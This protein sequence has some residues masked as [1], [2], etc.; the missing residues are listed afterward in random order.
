MES[1]V[2]SLSKAQPLFTIAGVILNTTNLVDNGI[3]P[4]I[5]SLLLPSLAT[6]YGVPLL[7]NS[8]NH[9]F[10]IT[11]ESLFVYLVGFAL[12]LVFF[13]NRLVLFFIGELP[14]ISKVISS[15][16][17]IHSPECSKEIITNQIISALLGIAIRRVVLRKS[18]RLKNSD[19]INILIYNSAIFTIRHFNLPAMSIVAVVYAAP[20]YGLISRYPAKKRAETPTV[21]HSRRQPSISQPSILHT[22]M[23]KMPRRRASVSSLLDIKK[24]EL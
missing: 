24:K 3:S 12:S 10:S 17:T 6:T 14:N 21:A 16:Q 13:S 19:I 2:L 7:M 23:S 11:P 5:Q 1:R 9:K 22:P 20:V 8:L 15:I 18:M 4:S